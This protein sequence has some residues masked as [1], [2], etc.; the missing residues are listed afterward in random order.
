MNQ[1]KCSA[2]I[3]SMKTPQNVDF[4]VILYFKTIYTTVDRYYGTDNFRS[5]IFPS[6]LMNQ[7]NNWGKL[8]SFGDH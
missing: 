5:I 1:G 8:D 6:D 3:A 2:N 4:L 7:N